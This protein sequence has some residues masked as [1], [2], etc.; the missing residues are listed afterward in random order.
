M[1]SLKNDKYRKTRGGYSRL[2]KIT[3]QECDAAVCSYQ[4]DGQ[5][6]LR[7]MYLDRISDP[8]VSLGEKEL[9]CSKGHLLGTR[10]I[11][12]KENRHAFRLFVDAVV[13]KIAKAS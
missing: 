6:S 8:R 11:Y 4:K 2:L 9:L 3:C 12:K 7:R 5:G 1:N 10:I 13:K